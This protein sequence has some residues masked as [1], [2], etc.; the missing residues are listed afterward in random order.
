MY[1]QV[2]HSLLNQILDEIKP[3]LRER[4]LR[5]F[6]TRLGAN[7]YVIHQLFHYLYGKRE[8]FKEQMIH[9]VEV[10]ATRYIQR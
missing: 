1:E 3:E 8:D 9:L 7:F 10:M 2:S 5:H 6:Y 4:D